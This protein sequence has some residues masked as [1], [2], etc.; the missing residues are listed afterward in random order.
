MWLHRVLRKTK[1]NK[2]NVL[3]LFHTMIQLQGAHLKDTESDMNLRRII[4]HL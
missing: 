1:D 2:N 3:G 4:N